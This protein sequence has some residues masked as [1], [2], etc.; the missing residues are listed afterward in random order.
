MPLNLSALQSGIHDV[1]ANPAEDA[2]GCAQQWAQALGDY[3]SAIVPAS[4]TVEAARATLASLLA[5]AFVTSS[6][7]PGMETAFA[8]FAATVGGGQAGF[9]PVP[10]PRSVGF[11]ALLATLQPTHDSAAA[12][13]AALID[14]WMR[15][16]SSA[17]VGGGSPVPWS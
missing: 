10:P 4:A 15:T 7:A 6:A 12:A 1:C 17:P 3:A 14:S 2:G 16:G 11:A 8:A 5:A 9:V 13:V